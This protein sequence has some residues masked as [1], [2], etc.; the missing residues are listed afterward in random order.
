MT[1]PEKLRLAAVVLLYLVPVLAGIRWGLP[2]SWH[3]NTY[4]CDENSPMASLQAMH[5][6]RLDFNP[7]GER[8]PHALGDGTFH[9]YTLGA[10]FKALTAARALKLTADRE[11][12]YSHPSEWARFYLA[13]RGLSAVYGALSV[14]ALYLLA[15]SMFGPSA[16][17]LAALFLA[18]APVQS[19]Y[20]RYM[21]VNGPGA[22]WAILSLLF[23]KRL[24]DTGET[25]FYL[26]SAASIGIAVSTRYSGAPLL[27]PYLA[28]HFLGPRRR[29][30]KP[31]LLGAPVIAA[32]FLAGTP[33]AALDYPD[34]LKGVRALSGTIAE[35]ASRNGLPEAV[36]ALLRTSADSIGAAMT[37]AA[38]A[39][40]G[41]AAVKRT[42]DDLL[43]AAWL[44]PMLAI[45]AKAAGAV[46]P[47]RMLPVVPFAALLAA[48]LLAQAGEKL[49][50]LRNAAAAL[51][52]A[53]LLL[54][55]AATVRLALREDP[56]DEASR[57]LAENAGPRAAIGLVREPSWFYPGVIEL[58]YRHPGLPALGDAAIV[59]LS[60]DWNY[61]CGYELLGRKLPDLVVTTSIDARYAGDAGLE[62][63]LRRLGYSKAAEFG[64][65]FSLLGIRLRRRLPVMLMTPDWI[66]IYSRP[67]KS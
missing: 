4:H 40:L 35:G 47:G 65:D 43:L 66:R 64:A 38:L 28:A 51:I 17:L 25:R 11:F 34:F 10:A 13:G 67:G 56:R 57:W 54:L 52:L 48:R 8:T 29:E 20:G 33:Y 5:P 30:L 27:L 61:G 18:L 31:L 44:L 36:L 45:F 60:R 1:R 32:A 6:S 49:P 62:P 37:A 58:K 9:I 2:N 15:R 7:V 41:W 55:Q 39:G 16:A 46:T 42:K 63:E 53:E 50:S 3:V 21:L 19:V 12:Y 22:F 23:L 14:I 26:L 24:M 59:P